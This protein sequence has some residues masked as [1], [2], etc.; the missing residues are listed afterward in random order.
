MDNEKRQNSDWLDDFLQSPDPG[1]E[2]EADE[3]AVSS[4]GLSSMADMELEKIMQEIMAQPPVEPEPEEPQPPV[5]DTEYRDVVPEEAEPP[6]QPSKPEPEPVDPNQPVRKVRPKRKSGYGLFGLPHL[7]STAI[8]VALTIF[9]GVSLGRLLWLCAADVLA[10]GREDQVVTLTITEHDNLDS[11]TDKLYSSGLIRYPRLFKLY[12]GIS[13]AEDKISV[14]TFTLN[15]LYDYHAVV[16][17]MSATSS[18]RKTVKVVIPEGYTCAQIF[19]LL[20]ERG[21]C[22]AKALEEYAAENDFASYDFLEGVQR[23]D[24]YMLEGFLF[25]DTYEF[26]TNDSPR[27]VYI[28]FLSGFASQFDQ[29]M[30]DQIATL[31]ETLSEKM[32]R[33]GYDEAYIAAHQMTLREVMIVASMIERETA[34]TGENTTIA[35]VIYNRLT[36]PNYP[37]LDIDATLVY[38]LGGKTDLT[39]EDKEI[40]SPYN[41]YK[42]E[43]LPPTP[44]SN[45]GLYSI[46]AALAPADTA[47]YFYALDPEDGAHHFS[48]TYE[49]HVAFLNS[50]D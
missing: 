3:Q 16:N 5:Q 44:I 1:A 38:A 46:K 29:E 39:A 30:K 36:N 12:A 6:A 22:S 25:P 37:H 21:V 9:I 20:E 4:A 17:G 2:L 50:L 40:D 41:T 28:K 15:T 18:Y 31:N 32:R 8:W 26:Y 27:H 49:E 48:R 10:F 11:I 19:A 34:H 43:G 14:G 45:P 23:G 13:H 47:Y 42:C 33:N 35:S 24:K 7:V